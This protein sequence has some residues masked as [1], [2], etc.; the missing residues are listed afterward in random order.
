MDRYVVING[1]NL[2]LL[3]ERE[4]EVYGT[5]TLVELTEETRKFAENMDC[6]L[7]F[8][9]SNHEGELID[10]LHEQRKWASGVIIN[11]GALTHYSYSLRDAIAAVNLPAVE[12]HLSNI[13]EREAFRAR[14][15][16]QDVCGKRYIGMGLRGY[17]RAI[18]HLKG[19]KT[20]TLVEACAAEGG[21]EESVRILHDRHPKYTWVGVYLVEGDELHLSSFVGSPT[22]HERIAIGEGI[23]GAAAAQAE[24]IIVADVAAD[25]RYLACS[26][27]TKSEIVVPIFWG[28][29][30]IGE[31]DI[32]S[33]LSNAFH[34]DDKAMLETCAK[35]LG[36]AL[37]TAG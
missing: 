34:E 13:L 28:E 27:E 9:Q 25:P 24:S 8:L 11:P 12:V 33:D 10:F 30:V 17:L 37:G 31:I 36:L 20:A 19:L 4:P 3:G 35:S 7:R 29:M 1:P 22:P 18:E 5:L 16:V 14:S 6:E 32:D 26:I 2:N 23:C 15:V 21:I